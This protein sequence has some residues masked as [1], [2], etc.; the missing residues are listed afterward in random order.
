MS[1]SWGN[2]KDK[3]MWLFK[4]AYIIYVYLVKTIVIAASV[5]RQQQVCGHQII[6]QGLLEGLLNLSATQRQLF[7]HILFFFL[8]KNTVNDKGKIILV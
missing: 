5:S 2:Q 6:V 7:N 8:K 1:D 3:L 4:Y